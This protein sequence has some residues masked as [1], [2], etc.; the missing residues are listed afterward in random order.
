[1]PTPLHPALRLALAAPLTLCAAAPLLLPAATVQAAQATPAEQTFDIAPGSLAAALNQFSGQAGIYLAGSNELAAGKTSRG[2]Q[3]RYS[4]AQG[5]ALLLQCSGL[6]AVPQGSAGYVLQP[7]PQDGVLQ[8]DATAINAGLLTANGQSDSGYRAVTSNTASK[9][10]AALAETPRSVSVVTRQRMDD[11]Q[12]QTLTEVLGYV[13]G[14]FSPPFAGGDGQAGDLFFIRGFNATDYGYGLLR[15]GLRVQGNRY[16]TS[17]EPYGLERVEV[18]RGPTSILYG[19]NAPG[20]VVTWSASAP[21]PMR[22]ARCS[23]ATARTT[24]ASWAW[25]S[26]GH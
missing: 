25:T 19:E 21:P 2:L 11:Q 22:A 12:S 3:G 23:S 17:S 13:P 24:A 20:G 16:D 8:L 18:F 14:I 10:G 26:L 9:T 7:A 5:L 15:D 1:M 4:V 6:Q